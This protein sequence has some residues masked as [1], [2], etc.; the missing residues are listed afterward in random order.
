[1]GHSLGGAVALCTRSIVRCASRADNQAFGDFQQIGAFVDH[2]NN[3]RYRESL[4][5]LTAADV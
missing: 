1:M 4:A 2:Y 3:H 5:N